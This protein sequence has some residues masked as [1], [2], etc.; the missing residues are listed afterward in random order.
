MEQSGDWRRLKTDVKV[1]PEAELKKVP[2]LCRTT[3]YYQ[4]QL[5]KGR[6]YIG[7][8]LLNYPPSGNLYV[9]T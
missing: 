9:L 8:S 4:L 1:M 3:R 7:P 6:I 2:R 5:S